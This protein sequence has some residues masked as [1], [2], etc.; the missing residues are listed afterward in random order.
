MGID[1]RKEVDSGYDR[2]VIT[3]KII[4]EML[5]RGVPLGIIEK[6]SNFNIR[7]REM[8]NNL[9]RGYFAKLEQ[10]EDMYDTFFENPKDGLGVSYS[11]VVHDLQE[12]YPMTP[13]EEKEK[14]T[15]R[16]NLNKQ[17]TKEKNKELKS[18]IR[19]REVVINKI[20]KLK[21]KYPILDTIIDMIVEMDKFIPFP[22]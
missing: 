20:V 1:Y 7:H 9:K 16:E 17:I 13:I 22:N 8:L 12:L 3:E 19:R 10:V 21:V 14:F 15:K 4:M 6:N 18:L 5:N 2:K 11:E